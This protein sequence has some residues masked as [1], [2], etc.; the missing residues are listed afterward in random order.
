V[1]RGTSPLGAGAARDGDQEED[2]T[3]KRTPDEEAQLA[4]AVLGALGTVVSGR[5]LSKSCLIAKNRSRQDP[6]QYV[7]ISGDFWRFF[8]CVTIVEVPL[9]KC[10]IL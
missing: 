10:W 2:V 7:T 9:E 3:G 4:A 8:Q 6:N 5:P 1:R